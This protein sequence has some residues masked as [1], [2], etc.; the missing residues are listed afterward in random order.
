MA[1]R[2]PQALALANESRQELQSGL[3]DRDLRLDQFDL[4]SFGQDGDSRQALRDGDPNGRGASEDTEAA[5]TP[6]A[7]APPRRLGAAGEVDLHA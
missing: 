6:T 7:A 1:A 4:R 3:A 2:D 5:E